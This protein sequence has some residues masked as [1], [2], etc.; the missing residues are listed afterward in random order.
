MCQGKTMRDDFPLISLVLCP[1]EF[2]DRM[3]EVRTMDNKNWGE[4]F[5]FLI[6]DKIEVMVV[7]DKAELFSP[8][9]ERR[10]PFK[11]SP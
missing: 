3:L 1:E 10:E 9:G 7:Y 4:L 6:R 2:G 5:T 8:P 11:E